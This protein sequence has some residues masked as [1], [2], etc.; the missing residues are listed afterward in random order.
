MTAEKLE[1]LNKESVS[2]TLAP[3]EKRAVK[4][5]YKNI[6]SL[7][8][9]TARL[10]K[11]RTLSI[12]GSSKPPEPEMIEDPKTPGVP[13]KA[14][15]H[16]LQFAWYAVLFMLEFLPPNWELQ[17]N[18]PRLESQIPLH[19][20]LSRTTLCHRRANPLQR[21]PSR[22][23]RLRSWFDRHRGV[24]H[25]RGILPLLQ[26]AQAPFKARKELELP[27]LQ[28]GDQ[29]HVGGRGERE[30]GQV[31]PDDEEQPAAPRSELELARD[32]VGWGGAGGGRR[33]L[34]CCC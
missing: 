32:G 20:S 15:E 5:G 33:D 11:T 12:D 1:K 24:R 30:W 29:A 31:G 10:A 28:I 19:A 4:V 26:L 18:I 2:S 27:P 21:A 7:D 25:R 23:D 17:D 3:P 14:P 22:V 13:I 9:I 6:P 16:P 34:W 8:A